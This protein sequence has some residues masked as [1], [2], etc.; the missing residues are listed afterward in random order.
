MI[1]KTGRPKGFADWT[2][3]QA[4]QTIMNQVQDVLA[5]YRE[6]WPLTIRQIFY[7]LVGVHGYDKTEQAY[8]RLCDYLT[9][10]RRS[11][12]IPMEAIRDDGTTRQDG[13]GWQDTAHFIRYVVRQARTYGR[14]KQARQATRTLI[15]VEAAGMLPQIVK[16]VGVYGLP[17][18]SSSG[19]DSLTMKH[20]LAQDIIDDGRPTVVLHIGDLDPSG[21]CIFDSVQADVEAFVGNE[22]ALLFKRIALTPEQVNLYNLPTKP[23]KPTDKRGEGISET[24]QAEALTPD[25]LAGIVRQAALEY[26]DMSQYEIDRYI[27]QQERTDLIEKI[28]GLI[29]A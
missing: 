5:Q 3:Q 8:N 11:R 22:Q 28:N 4:T 13:D 14:N 21:V 29:A 19:F 24:C 20:E 1:Y 6:H 16:A 25:T 26:I 9:R 15:L 2:P 27:E 18:L 17:V 10:G 7:R 12:M 23:P